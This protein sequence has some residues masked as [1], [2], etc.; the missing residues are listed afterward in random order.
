[1]D[2][3]LWPHT[4]SLYEMPWSWPPFQGLPIEHCNTLDKT[5]EVQ[6]KDGFTKIPNKRKLGH[7]PSKPTTQ[8]RNTTNN[9]F[10]ILSNVVEETALGNASWEILN[11]EMEQGRVIDETQ[12]RTKTETLEGTHATTEEAKINMGEDSPEGDTHGNSRKR[13]R[14]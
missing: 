7:K 14:Y 13:W 2:Y 5:K 10:E 1:M 12:K 6:N 4:F 9:N 3:K 8:S 11:K